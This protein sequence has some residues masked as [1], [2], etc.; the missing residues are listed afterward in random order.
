MVG[1]YN[2]AG[3]LMGNTASRELSLVAT[4]ATD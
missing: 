1:E 2:D 3:A 4:A